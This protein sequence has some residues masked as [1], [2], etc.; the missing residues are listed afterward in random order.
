MIA[1]H[2][3]APGRFAGRL[4]IVLPVLLLAAC[5]TSTTLNLFS[6]APKVCPGVA[7]P[8]LTDKLTTFKAGVGRDLIDVTFKADFVG[9]RLD[10]DTP[11]DNSQ[12]ATVVVVEVT[13]R[14]GPAVSQNDPVEIALPIFVAKT[15]Q[16]GDIRDKAVYKTLLKFAEGQPRALTQETFDVTFTLGPGETPA[17]LGVLVGFQLNKEQLDYNRRTER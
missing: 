4:A 1:P 17:D 11:D 9:G 14:R 6:S 12:V 10:C 3:A 16:S 13:A 8:P 7:V 15:D 5:S 2:R